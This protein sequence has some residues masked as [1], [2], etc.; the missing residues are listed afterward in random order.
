MFG[1]EGGLILY[2]YPNEKHNQYPPTHLQSIH[3]WL[4][5]LVDNCTFFE[6]TNSG[7]ADFVQLR[8]Q[9]GLLQ[10]MHRAEDRL[11]RFNAPLTWLPLNDGRLHQ[12]TVR[13]HPL[14]WTVQLDQQSVHN[15]LNEDTNSLRRFNQI[16]LGSILP[17]SV[18]S[19]Q[20]LMA[21]NQESSQ[22]TK[23][24]QWMD[25]KRHSK[26]S[27]NDQKTEK[28]FYHPKTSVN[29]KEEVRSIERL[30]A[31]EQLLQPEE[32]ALKLRQRNFNGVLMN[33]RVNYVRPLDLC[34]ERN[35][36]IITRGDVRLLFSLPPINLS[37]FTLFPNGSAGFVPTGKQVCAVFKL[38]S[39][40]FEIVNFKYSKLETINECFF[41]LLVNPKKNS[42]C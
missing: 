16:K 21:L 42:R 37:G 28:A 36:R 38:I 40:L 14:G 10:L 35:S 5:T 1:H 26:L 12:L 20:H 17:N 24:D 15:W 7:N 13:T 30:L 2:T 6:L 3:L 32:L 41:P 19:E 29:L 4:A 9:A 33:V 18:L 25:K 23:F 34:L 31:A 11:Q 39:V 27:I 8:L 22:P